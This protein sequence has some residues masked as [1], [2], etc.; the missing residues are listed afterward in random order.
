MILNYVIILI[1]S[2][3]LL[4]ALALFMSIYTMPTYLCILCLL[5]YVYP[6][7]KVYTIFIILLCDG[8]L[9][10]THCAVKFYVL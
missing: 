6:M 3:A 4:S 1:Q 5:I 9:T 8:I 2:T 10:D 7:P